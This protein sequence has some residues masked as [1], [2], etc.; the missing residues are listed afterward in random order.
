MKDNLYVII[1]IDTENLQTPLF[2]KKY[3]YDLIYSDLGVHQILKILSHF[4]FSATFFLNVFEYSIWG[5]EKMTMISKAI[6]TEGSDVQLHTHPL[7]KFDPNREH[8]WQYSINEQI[9]IIRE[10][11]ELIKEWTGEYPIAHRA[12]AYGLN[13]NTLIAL[14]E[15]NIPIDSSM[16]YSHPNCKITWTRNKILERNGIIE[17]PVTGFYRDICWGA[18]PLSLKIRRSFVKTDID[19]ASLD[20]LKNF[21]KEA[22]EHNIRVMTLF[23]HSYSFI[24]WDNEFVNFQPDYADIEKFT[25]FLEF[26]KSDKEI[27]VITMGEF[28]KLYKENPSLF[29][30]SDYVPVIRRRESLKNLIYKVSNKIFKYI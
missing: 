12:G 7:W 27:E 11:K 13:E 4:D 6:L 26:I 2:R 14:K 21:V 10:G 15:N 1:T 28:Y 9:E 25:R 24:K 20:E 23:M 29:N 18:G 16:F 30:G 8:M 3:I 22:K 17:V 5:R 19:W